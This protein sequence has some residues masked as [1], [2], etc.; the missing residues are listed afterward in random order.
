MIEIHPVITNENRF[1]GGRHVAKLH[2]FD[3][4]PGCPGMGGWERSGY[5]G[6]WT[7][8]KGRQASR[9]LRLASFAR[10]GMVT[11]KMDG[12]RI[13]EVTP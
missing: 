7:L 9:V 4:P 11:I 2:V 13:V 12:D 8:I 1:G 6:W 5:G 10:D 3:R